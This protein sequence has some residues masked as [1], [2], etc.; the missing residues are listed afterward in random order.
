M[1][2]E[3]LNQLISEAVIKYNRMTP[4]ERARH[5]YEQRKSWVRGMTAGCEH[6]VL[7]FETC[8]D[9]RGWR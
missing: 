8:P 3:I 5:D 1:S 9:C 7:D 2:D 4:T 6:G